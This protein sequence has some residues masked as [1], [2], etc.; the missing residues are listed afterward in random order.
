MKKP[1]TLLTFLL[2]LLL[3][4]AQD[5]FVDAYDTEIFGRSLIVTPQK[6]LLVAGQRPAPNLSAT[7]T[8]FS[9]FGIMQMQTDGNP[10]MARVYHYQEHDEWLY[11]QNTPN[12]FVLGGESRPSHNGRENSA[13]V[14]ARTDYRGNVKWSKAFYPYNTRGILL[15]GLSTHRNKQIVFACLTRVAPSGTSTRPGVLGHLVKLDS[16][17]N[18]IWRKTYDLGDQYPFA[19]TMRGSVHFTA[20]G[21]LAAGWQFSIP[22]PATS[23]RPFVKGIAFQRFD[24]AGNLRWTRAFRS[25]GLLGMTYT[26]QDSGVAAYALDSMGRSGMIKMGKGG[27]VKYLFLDALPNNANV[28]TVPRGANIKNAQGGIPYLFADQL[29]LSKPL[30]SATSPTPPVTAAFPA[31]ANRPQAKFND[32][33]TNGRAAYITGSVYSPV[34]QKR[35]PVLFKSQFAAKVDNCYTKA[36]KTQIRRKFNLRRVNTNLPTP[37][38]T[39]LYINDSTIN[40]RNGLVKAQDSVVCLGNGDV[41]PGDANSDGFAEVKDIMTLGLVWGNSGPARPNASPQWLAQPARNWRGYFINGANHKHADCNGNGRVGVADL[42]VILANYGRRHNKMAANGQPGDAPIALKAP[43]SSVIPGK[44]IDIPVCL[45]DAT[46]SEAIHG[47][48]FVVNY[49]PSMVGEDLQ[50]VLNDSWLGNASTDLISI[51]KNFPADGVLEIGVSKINGLDAMGHGKIGVLRFTPK[52]QLTTETPFFFEINETEGVNAAQ[53]IISLYGHS[54][55]VTVEPVNFT[56]VV[57]N[58]MQ[59][60]PAETAKLSVHPNP[61]RD[62]LTIRLPEANMQKVEILNGFGQPMLVKQASGSQE[63]LSISYLPEGM[64]I[65]RIHTESGVVTQRIVKE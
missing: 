4:N 49:D 27:V 17:G 41:W 7:S 1:I 3:C 6:N 36:S 22:T 63:T 9:D 30:P 15:T 2:A 48:S 14:I 8:N 39:V 57:M 54:D 59:Q 29:T 11:A 58:G 31:I 33:V 23:A 10:L 46:A 43:T 65:V 34:H 61:T 21:G 50:F 60:A 38:L 20:Q 53:D 55:M 18:V 13:V 26:P 5:V 51:Q 12:G 62:Q 52:S 35:Y 32:F 16:A 24:A 47:F 19:A 40:M 64:Y 42:L 56:Q 45:G 28:N 37:P 25:N 44:P